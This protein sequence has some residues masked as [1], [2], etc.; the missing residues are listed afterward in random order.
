MSEPVVISPEIHSPIKQFCTWDGTSHYD[1]INRN[2]PS[3]S[4]RVAAL[5]GKV[6]EII[7]KLQK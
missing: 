4:N 2:V 3:L 1:I 7:R 5:E 6:E